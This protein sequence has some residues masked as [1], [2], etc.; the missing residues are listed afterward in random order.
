MSKFYRLETPSGEGI[1]TR[2]FYAEVHGRRG[3]DIFA[4]AKSNHPT[5]PCDEWE[6]RLPDPAPNIK[7]GFDSM[8]QLRRWFTKGDLKRAADLART[9]G[10]ALC[11]SVYELPEIIHGRAQCVADL[12][13]RKPR[14]RVPIDQIIPA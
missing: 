7:C 12:R 6:T 11:L 9:R 10:A 1:Y 13:D 5:P 8:K 3:F 4:N 14:K 2:F